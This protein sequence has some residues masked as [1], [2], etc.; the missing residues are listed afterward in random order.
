MVGRP[1][2]V[3]RRARR[4]IAARRGP[5]WLIRLACQESGRCGLLALLCGA[6]LCGPRPPRETGTPATASLTTDVSCRVSVAQVNATM[7]RTIN[8]GYYHPKRHEAFWHC[9]RVLKAMSGGVDVDI[10]K[11]LVD[12]VVPPPPRARMQK[13]SR[14]D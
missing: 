9:A 10:L 11:L 13:A 6:L 3:P 2:R 7:A 4:Q 12:K 14:V 5:V 8:M 1:H